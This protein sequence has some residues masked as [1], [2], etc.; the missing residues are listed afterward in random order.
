MEIVSNSL[1]ITNT[2]ILELLFQNNIENNKILDL[3][4]GYGYFTQ[5]VYNEMQKHG[6]DAANNLFASD[7]SPEDYKFNK[8][9]CKFGDFNKGLPYEDETFD[10]VCSIEVVEHIEDQFKY[11]REINRILKPGGRLLI[12]TPNI[13]N[14]NSRFAYM[15]YGAYFLFDILSINDDVASCNGHINPVSYTYLAYILK[16]SGFENIQ[17]YIDR[18]KKGGMFLSL[19]MYPIMFIA[20]YWHFK[21]IKT[22]QR[23]LYNEN[24][25]IINNINSFDM[26]TGRTIILSANKKIS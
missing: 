21:K 20:K 4:A 3:G 14:A 11:I 22:K 7:F 6:M 2:K 26:L 1:E 10:N 5:L 12:T 15:A 23:A 9:P 19:F 17:V 16:K 25:D 8:I 24:I 13:L 18:R